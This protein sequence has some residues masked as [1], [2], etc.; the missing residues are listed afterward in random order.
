MALKDQLERKDQRLQRLQR[1]LDDARACMSGMNGTAP[2]ATRPNP[3]ATTNANVG[4][5]TGVG[6]AQVQAQVQ[7]Q[8]LTAQLDAKSSQLADERDVRMRVQRDLDD[9]TAELA[10][11]ER[12]V[13]EH[14]AEMERVEA[15]NSKLASE[16][17]E[18]VQIKCF[19]ST[20]SN[21]SKNFNF[22]HLF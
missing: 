16:L 15:K 13:D 1:E 22:L 20:K 3:N 7:V 11:L 18:Q 17:Q 12:G 6:E 9:A 14:V 10:Q 5:N 2:S 21:V 8:A 19:T 4:A